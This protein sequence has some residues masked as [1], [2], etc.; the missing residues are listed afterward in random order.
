MVANTDQSG[1][2]TVGQRPAWRLCL[3]LYLLGLVF[4]TWLV[5]AGA[6]PVSP[7]Y[8]W[9]GKYEFYSVVQA[10]LHGGPTPWRVSELSHGTDYF[11]TNP[12]IPF[13][14]EVLLLAVAPIGKVV[15]LSFLLWYTVGF[16]GSLRLARQ[17]QWGG[18]AFLAWWLL[19]NGN[20]HIVAHLAIGHNEWLAYFLL[21]FVLEQVMALLAAP[22]PAPWAGIP[23]AVILG[24]LTLP[25]AFHL[26]IW[27]VLFIFLLALVARDRRRALLTALGGAMGLAAYRILP[28]VLAF[29][30]VPYP[31]R[32]RFLSVESFVAGMVNL[33]PHNTVIQLGE[34]RTGWW[35]FDFYLGFAGFVLVLGF[36]FIA[37]WW[38][39]PALAGSGNWLLLPPL[40]MM[41]ALSFINPKA[42]LG[43][44]SPERVTTRFF[45]LPFI[46]LLLLTV[47][48][49]DRLVKAGWRHRWV[50]WALL[51]LVVFDLGR[52]AAVWHPEEIYNSLGEPFTD[53]NLSALADAPPACFASMAGGWLL[54]L[55][56]AMGL[57]WW[58]RRANPAA[59]GVEAE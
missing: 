4:W 1:D 12:Q 23:L 36:G 44:W 28:A 53:L 46:F 22:A 2:R 7:V 48:R 58:W 33:Y 10:W 34:L 31:F 5:S 45:L 43:I 21:P 6:M 57:W 13:S 32:A 19:F 30:M 20:G 29:P 38:R 51:A 40:L 55:A 17:W 26:L 3:L 11:L 14:P 15:W 9:Y 8:D 59:R 27:C 54:T 52:H 41:T 47:I 49:I 16:Y 25:G 50:V 39:H 42:L 56:A 37:G 18:A 35:E 24:L